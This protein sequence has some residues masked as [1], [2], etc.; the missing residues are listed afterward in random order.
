VTGKLMK[1]INLK[2]FIKPLVIV[3]IVGVIILFI[4]DGIVMPFYVQKGKVT[5]VPNVIGLSLEDAKNRIRAAGLDPKGSDYKADKRYE[6]G[7]IILQN[8][9]ADS[10]VKYGRGIYLTISGGEENVEVPNL[11]GKSI[12]EAT[13]NLERYNLKLG[14]ISYEPSEEIFENTIIR[15]TPNAKTKM[16]G[17]GY[18]DVTV[19]QGKGTNAHLIP[20]VSMK[21]LTESEKILTNAGFHVGK[22]TYQINMDLLPNT[23][24]E[25]YPRAG[26]LIQLNQTVDLIV[27]QK[28]ETKTKDEN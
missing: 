6:I 2:G 5:K 4:V 18:I 26:E 28:A 25:Q 19:S 8:P 12:R 1:K 7:T 13:F 3:T 20:D 14:N 24:L 22:I 21:T 15:Q 9:L 16:K 10:E 23:V 17:G 27:A 11:R